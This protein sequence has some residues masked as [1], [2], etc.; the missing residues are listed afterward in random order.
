ME[1]IAAFYVV[2]F[3]KGNFMKTK[4]KQKRIKPAT[5]KE[6]RQQRKVIDDAVNL[7]LVPSKSQSAY[8]RFEEWSVKHPT[9]YTILCC[10]IV[11]FSFAWI[12]SAAMYLTSWQ[13]ILPITTHT[14]GCFPLVLKHQATS[15]L[16]QASC[17]V[18]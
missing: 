18:R 3:L 1:F 15:D 14:T 4:K 9:R 5:N 8:A 2:I 13:V 6:Q 12:V 17:A 10:V 16:I 11:L 7:A